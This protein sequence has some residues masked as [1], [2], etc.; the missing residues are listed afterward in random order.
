MRPSEILRDFDT[1]LESK[2]LPFEAVVI[3]GAA[4]ALLG[5]IVRETQDCDV[6]DPEIPHK[7]IKAANEFAQQKKLKLDWL[8]NGPESLKNILPAGWRDRISALYIGQSLTLHTLDRS[9]LLKTKLFAYCDRQQ[10]FADCIALKPTVKELKD[11]IHWIQA[12]DA[13]PGWPK[14]VD[15]SIA[16]LAKRLGHEL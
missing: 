14:H 4:L 16:A 5:V 10:D 9:D 12:Q 11:A 2:G 3:G 6:L 13:H 7:I 1:F 15:A 8:N